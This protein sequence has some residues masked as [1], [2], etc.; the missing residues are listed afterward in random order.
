MQLLG[1]KAIQVESFI[2]NGVCYFL[3]D[4]QSANKLIFPLK[5]TIAFCF[6]ALP[7]TYKI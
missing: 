1:I 2:T 5:I 6:L 3:L 7:L 4:L